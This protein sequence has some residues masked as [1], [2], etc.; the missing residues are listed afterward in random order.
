MTAISGWPLTSC[1]H[2]QTIR[3]PESVPTEDG[4]VI[5]SRWIKHGTCSARDDAMR[6][7]QLFVQRIRSTGRNA[8]C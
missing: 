5:S 8:D 2:E 7:A 4:S 6:K 3:N 1:W